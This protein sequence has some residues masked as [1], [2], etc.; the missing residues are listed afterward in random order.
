M[1]ILTE[2]EAVKRTRAP[3]WASDAFFLSD[4]MTS[5]QSIPMH[6][7]QQPLSASEERLIS[8]HAHTDTGADVSVEFETV[9]N[10]LYI[11]EEQARSGEDKKNGGY[12]TDSEDEHLDRMMNPRP[13]LGRLRGL[14]GRYKNSDPSAQRTVRER[15]LCV[16]SLISTG[17]CLILITLSL[18]HF[19]SAHS[20]DSSGAGTGSITDAGK[21]CTSQECV[22]SASRIVSKMDL[23][24]QPCDDFYEYACGRWD[25]EHLIPS[26]K[27]R[28]SQFDV[29]SDEQMVTLRAIMEAQDTDGKSEIEKEL[30]SRL[31]TLYGTCINETHVEKRGLEP[32]VPLMKELSSM[33]PFGTGSDIAEAMPGVFVDTKDILNDNKTADFYDKLANTTSWFHQRGMSVLFGSFVDQDSRQPEKYALHLAQS[34]LGL[35]SRE[36]YKDADKLIAYESIILDAFTTI[37]GSKDIAKLMEQDELKDA[38]SGLFVLE[39]L[40]ED[41]SEIVQF[42]TKLAEISWSNEELSDPIKTYNPM[43]LTDIQKSKGFEYGQYLKRLYEPLNLAINYDELVVINMT[44]SYFEKLAGLIERT[45]SRI[46]RHY[47]LWHLLLDYAEYLDERFH[48][49]LKKFKKL[50]S[51]STKSPDRWLQCSHFGSGAM[52]LVAGRAYVDLVF[53]Q[54]T[55]QQVEVMIKTIR[56]AFKDRLAHLEWLDEETREKALEKELMLGQKIGYPSYLKNDERLQEWYKLLKVDEKDFFSNA[57]NVNVYQTMHNLNRLN[58][59]V[60]PDE[61]SMDPQTVNA[62]YQPTRN[63]IVFPAAI[64]QPPFYDKV[65]PMAFHYGGIGAVVGHEITH[66]FDDHGKEF[67]GSGKMVSWWT[68]ESLT[69]FTNLSQCFVDQYSSFEIPA[70][71]ETSPSDD[72]HVNGKLTLGENLADNGGM[73]T[74]FQ[75]YQS[76]KSKRIRRDPVI[77]PG[78]EEMSD[79]K[80]FFLGYAQI[81][82]S[83]SRYAEALKRL[84]TDPHSPARARVNIPL[85]NSQA[86]QKAYGCKAGS[87]M[88]FEQKCKLW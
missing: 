14:S 86:F 71:P 36:Y 45:P 43:K 16:W 73:D 65:A 31:R 32:L 54:D 30:L 52:G 19:N 22:I 85:G 28:L 41:A 8:S 83:K 2:T 34:G 69:R 56:G 27:A 1:K 50:V 88:N 9:H 72:L 40:M 66:G 46:L 7:Y 3:D 11:T 60:D 58:Q 35:P 26:D 47:L 5:N 62:Y 39:Q 87:K 6:P 78:L 13:N 63:E 44:P 82:C 55:K 4:K 76:A 64:F 59:E 12:G 38:T 68:E 51:G 42:E 70:E 80:M 75:A 37:L 24:K 25:R 10:Q 20:E 23:T 15:R 48:G 67:D 53:N 61:W 33:F 17:L 84:R 29:L 57:V 79:E 77:L 18:S 74:S 21:L 49:P 81:W